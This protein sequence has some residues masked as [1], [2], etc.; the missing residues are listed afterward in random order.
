MDIR[1]PELR[2]TQ[3]RGSKP[4]C[5]LLTS[6]TRVEVAERLTSLIKPWGEV[7]A[8]GCCWMPS[9]FADCEEA[10][11]H[12]AEKIIADANDRDALLNW[13]LAVSGGPRTTTPN[14][15]IASTC[16]IHGKPG[17]LLIEA[18]AHDTELRNEERGKPLGG[19][20]NKG[21]SLDSRRNHVRIGCCIQEA[22][23]A[24]SQQ[25]GLAWALS[26]DWCYQMSNRFAW[27]WKLTELG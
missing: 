15:D 25:T 18:K 22:A 7:V 2:K 6:G 19:E 20:D 12:K 14:W 8:G 16:A 24:L 17:I 10:Q 27:A 21:V 23:I 1:F 9:G 26:R 11:L 3:Q 4:R 13:W 5:H